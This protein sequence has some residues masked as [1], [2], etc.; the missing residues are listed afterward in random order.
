VTRPAPWGHPTP[1]AIEE[2]CFWLATSPA[3]ARPA[4]VGRHEVDVI[5]VGGG[6]TGL[7][8]AIHLKLL[9][10]SLAIAVLEQRSI[11]YGASGRNAGMLLGTIDHSH[12][13]A[14]AHFGKREAR[15]LARVGRE[16]VAALLSFL[17][18]RAID[19]GLERTGELHMALTGDHVA[20]LEEERRAAAEIGVDDLELLDAEAARAEV[21]SPLY[22]GAL[23]EPGPA[24]VD[25]A[26]LV[27]GLAREAERLGCLIHEESAVTRVERAGAGVRVATAGGELVAPR[28]VLGTNAYTHHLHPPARH[29]FMPLYDYILVSEPLGE[30]E[31]AAIGWKKRQG[32]ADARNFFNY[33]R[34]TPDDRILWGTSEAVYYPG[35]RVDESCDHS[36]AH[37][38]ALR[39]GFARHFPQLAGLDFPYAWGGPIAATTRFTPFFGSALGGKLLYALGYTGHG[40]ATTHLAGRILAHLALE[41]PTPLRDLALVRELPLPFPPE[42]MRGWAVRAVTRELRRVDEGA[43]PSPLLRVLDALGIGLSS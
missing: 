37:Y 31:R 22:R 5:V 19:V 16:N 13:M 10:P 32:V 33:Y 4:L 2:A 24:L 11:G 35:D 15:R 42:P 30:S 7:W 41:R 20:D 1:R 18:E 21:H 8:T 14:I 40:V 36:E 34:W 27:T 26:R 6:F 12:G 17:E 25:P 38:R 43:R 39:E 23:F 3:T 29:R 9:E 28:V